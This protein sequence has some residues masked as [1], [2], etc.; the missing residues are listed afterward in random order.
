M[1][2]NTLAWI[3]S[4]SAD[5]GSAATGLDPASGWPS[6]SRPT[7]LPEQPTNQALIRAAVLRRRRALEAAAGRAPVLVSHRSVAPARW[8]LVTAVSAHQRA[9][10]FNAG[11]ISLAQ[12]PA[13]ADHRG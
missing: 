5:N 6:L 3:E 7:P 4:K 2:V 9:A 1:G 12:R 11:D 10:S 8:D 13:T